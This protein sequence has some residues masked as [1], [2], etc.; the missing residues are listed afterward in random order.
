MSWLIPVHGTALYYCISWLASII[1]PRDHK[2]LQQ[3]SQSPYWSPFVVLLKY[4]CSPW[5]RLFVPKYA[6]RRVHSEC[7][8]LHSLPHNMLGFCTRPKA[9]NTIRFL[10]PIGNMHF[11]G[12]HGGRETEKALSGR[13]ASRIS[14]SLAFPSLIRFCI[15]DNHIASKKEGSHR[16]R[17]RLPWRWNIFIHQ[18]GSLSCKSDV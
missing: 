11:G 8:M 14:S 17:V 9:A 12:W 16:A 5:L 10:G 7:K 2:F 6:R 15:R 18:T 1:Q 13:T 3:T 4:N